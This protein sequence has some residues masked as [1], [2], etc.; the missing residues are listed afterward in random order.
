MVTVDARRKKLYIPVFKQI[1]AGRIDKPVILLSGSRGS[2]KSTSAAQM[3]ARAGI[4]GSHKRQVMIRK[5]FRYIRESQYSD[6]D[7]YHAALGLSGDINAGV[8]PLKY[9]YPNSS[10]IISIG[11]DKSKIKSLAGVQRAWVEEATEMTAADWLDLQLTVLR[12]SGN[13]QVILTYNPRVGSWVNDEFFY[14][15]GSHKRADTHYLHTTYLDN[16]FVGD[17]F[18][19]TVEALSPDLYKIHGLGLLVKPKG[20]IYPDFEVI[21]SFPENITWVYGADKGFNDPFAVVRVGYDSDTLYFDEVAYETGYT[22]ADMIRI[23]QAENKRKPWYF[24]DSAADTIREF[25]RAGFNATKA[26]KGQIM[27]GINRIRQ[28][29]IKITRQ[30]AMLLKEIETYSFYENSDGK[31]FDEPS[32]G[33]AEHLCD[34]FRYASINL[35]TKRGASA[36]AGG[37]NLAAK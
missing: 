6:I 11:L 37:F 18:R 13:P 34:A 3:I 25:Q 24:D 22:N 21:E 1:I 10:E 29:K 19:R 8:S 30:S 14:P 17:T 32:P 35:V 7:T 36:R 33:Q 16:P 31:L 12:G 20:L 2:G 27:D 5:W 28:C 9:E 4:K 15:D 23:L 26:G